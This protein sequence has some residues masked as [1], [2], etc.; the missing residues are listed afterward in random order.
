[1][2]D[3]RDGF[4]CVGLDLSLRR[5]GFSY[6]E[7]DEKFISCARREY[8]PYDKH[9]HGVYLRAQE[10]LGFVKENLV[11]TDPAIISL[12]TALPKGQWAAGL[13]GLD[14]LTLGWLDGEFPNAQIVLYHPSFLAHIHGMRKY[15]KSDSVK[16]AK[17]LIE[18][19]E[20]K[21]S[22]TRMS[23]D[24]A[25]AVIYAYAGAVKLGW[26]PSKSFERFQCTKGI[27]M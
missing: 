17:A 4:A 7:L 13:F 12:E 15:K 1:M 26:K 3:G 8:P 24:E 22:I 2:R 5:P 16:L 23:H 21:G 20:L 6:I 19:E 14:L 9:F 11:G 25:E 27:L 10:V 18:M